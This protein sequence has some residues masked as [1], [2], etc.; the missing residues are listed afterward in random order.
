MILILYDKEIESKWNTTS[1]IRHN[2]LMYTVYNT[3][4]YTHLIEAEIQSVKQQIVSIY[5][6]R[7]S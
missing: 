6:G 1:R 5:S 4:G 7:V 2:I 3:E